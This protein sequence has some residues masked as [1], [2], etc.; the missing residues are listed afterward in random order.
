MYPKDR[1]NA[2]TDGVF[3]VAMTLL[4]LDV[5]LP[6]EFQPHDQGELISALGGLTQKVALYALSFYVLGSSWLAST[7]IRATDQP[8]GKTFGFWWLLY[9]FL[10]T[11]IPFSTTLVGRFAH[12]APSVWAYSANLGLMAAVGYRATMLQVGAHEDAHVHERKV[13]LLLLFC[14][15]VL[16]ILV[17][18]AW[19]K[20]SQW[21]YALNIAASPIASWHLASRKKRRGS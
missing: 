17:S 21:A 12:L 3:A 2:L 20:A 7:K 9:L 5:R 4:I 10:A 19:P 1:I 11:C 8:L 16:A 13:S 6:E 18:F 14:S 15:S